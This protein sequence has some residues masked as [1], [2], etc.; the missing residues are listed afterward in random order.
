MNKRKV[1]LHL[2]R[3]GCGT[4]KPKNLGRGLCAEIR[5]LDIPSEWCTHILELIAKHPEASNGDYDSI[6]PPPELFRDGFVQLRNLWEP[7][8]QNN[9][10]DAEYVLRRLRLCRW[11]AAL[12][13]GEGW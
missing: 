6:A 2:D 7:E 5:D 11:L 3:L 4:Q 12:L 13:R 9:Y 10:D 1:R 8:V